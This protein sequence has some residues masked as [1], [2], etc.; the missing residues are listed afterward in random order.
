MLASAIAEVTP[1]YA[2]INASDRE[3]V[4]ARLH[5]EALKYLLEKPDLILDPVRKLLP[6][7][8]RKKLTVSQF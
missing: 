3:E 7:E 2:R 6:S 8:R 4:I 5:F 1:K